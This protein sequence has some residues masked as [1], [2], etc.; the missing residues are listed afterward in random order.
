[1]AHLI[2]DLPPAQAWTLGRRWAQQSADVSLPSLVDGQ[3][4]ELPV[5]NIQ[6]IER[7]AAQY[8]S[9]HYL[10]MRRVEAWHKSDSALESSS[11]RLQVA[12]RIGPSIEF[13]GFRKAVKAAT[14]NA[15]AGRVFSLAERQTEGLRPCASPL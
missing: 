13:R 3:E 6:T 4:R 15:R 7:V 1:V 12:R 9:S 8:T 5:N 2:V 14:R 11:R 10:P